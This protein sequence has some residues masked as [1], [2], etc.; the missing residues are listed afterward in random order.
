MEEKKYKYSYNV[1]G[2]L[3]S[4][5]SGYVPEIIEFI[6]ALPY[7][8][9][10]P[11]NKSWTI[12][13]EDLQVFQARFPQK[14]F[15]ENNT[16]SKEFIEDIQKFIENY[17]NSHKYQQSK[18]YKPSGLHCLRKCVFIRAGVPEGESESKYNW[19]GCAASGSARHE[20]IQDYLIKMTE[21][22]N[23]KW[24]YIDVGD[25]V[26]K[27]H[28]EGKCLEVEV[29][30]KSGAETHLYNNT[31]HLSF[32]C[33][34]I[35]QYRPT[36]E[37]YLFEFKNKTSAKAKDV[38]EMPQEH[39]LQ[40]VCYCMNL[41]LSKVLLL[42]ENRDTCELSIPPLYE[43]SEEQKK[44]LRDDLLFA[45]ECV[46]NKKIPDRVKEQGICKFCSYA[47]ICNK[48]EEEGYNPLLEV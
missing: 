15:I 38:D 20:Y 36:G 28:Q 25:Y 42:V 7:R 41:D 1:Q 34:G 18:T 31:L 11:D 8:K 9:W 35:V 10:N 40:V 5:E 29:G 27:K 30:N 3:T 17:N 21:D 39:I 33:D 46:G 16:I 19:S 26:E 47:N 48:I 14:E 4:I 37:Y 44:K 45:E 24:S 2:D 32:L 22:P 12:K 6:K 43:V 23:S 13:T